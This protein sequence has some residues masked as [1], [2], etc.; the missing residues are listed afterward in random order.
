MLHWYPIKQLM[1]ELTGAAVE[2]A[3]VFE[4]TSY[5]ENQMT[6]VILQS[7]DELEKLNQLKKIQ[8]LYQKNR[9]DR[10]C[11]KN[12]IKSLSEEDNSH[13]PFDGGSVVKEKKDKEVA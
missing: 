2:K 4:L 13:L 8:G 9:I 10:D 6:K 7:K 11:I 12:A 5:F 1:H 3:A